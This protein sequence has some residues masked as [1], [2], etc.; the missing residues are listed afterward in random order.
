MDHPSEFE[1]E[2]MDFEGFNRAVMP[3][4]LPDGGRLLRQKASRLVKKSA[5]SRLM[6]NYW[7]FKSRVD[8]ARKILL[9][10]VVGVQRIQKGAVFESR[11]RGCGEVDPVAHQKVYFWAGIQWTA[12]PSYS[13]F[14]Y[15]RQICTNIFCRSASKIELSRWAQ[16]SQQSLC[17]SSMSSMSNSPALTQQRHLIFSKSD[18]LGSL[19]L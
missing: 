19:A 12:H 5:K 10:V 18:S 1:D 17:M 2:R 9:L 15:G 16:L 8:C 11:P 4:S 7:Y 6:D 13:S 3:A 14:S